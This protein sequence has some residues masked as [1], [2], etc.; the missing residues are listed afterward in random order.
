[1]PHAFESWECEQAYKSIDPSN[2]ADQGTCEYY[3]HPIVMLMN[4]IQ[5]AG[6][7]LTPQTVAQGV[8]RMGYSFPTDPAWAIGGGYGPDD[9]SY[10]DNVGVTWWSNSRIDPNTAEPGAYV[11]VQQGKR[12]K[13]GEIPADN[14]EMF[15]SGVTGPGQTD[16]VGG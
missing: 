14:S 9:F 13:R 5:E 1:L 3:W 15:Q 2:T 7:H 11:W 10:M 4:M 8:N 16:T 12:F 6:P